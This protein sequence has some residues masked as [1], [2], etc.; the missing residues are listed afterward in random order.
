MSKTYE[1]RIKSATVD[2]GVTVYADDI[3]NAVFQAGRQVTNY[4]AWYPRPRGDDTW[5]V[6]NITTVEI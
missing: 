5:K 4:P 2:Y 1:V 6:I 3:L